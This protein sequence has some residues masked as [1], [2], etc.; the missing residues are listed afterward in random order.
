MY[1]KENSAYAYDNKK[2][3]VPEIAL[4]TKVEEKEIWGIKNAIVYFDKY[5]LTDFGWSKTANCKEQLYNIHGTSF[6]HKISD[7]KFLDFEV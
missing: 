7:T 3:S 6:L 2:S 1:T 4:V 5:T